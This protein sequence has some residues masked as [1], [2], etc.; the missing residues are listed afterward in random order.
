MVGA[1]DQ[2]AHQSG[3]GEVM[4]SSHLLKGTSTGERRS[5]PSLRVEHVSTSRREALT[6]D[7]PD[8]GLSG[9]RKGPSPLCQFQ[10]P[11]AGPRNHLNGS[12]AKKLTDNLIDGAWICES[13]S[14]RIK[15]CGNQIR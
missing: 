2:Q 11:R 6:R 12:E 4:I 5:A 9:A 1:H 8:E 14:D 7:N 15:G 10:H 3:D 13:L